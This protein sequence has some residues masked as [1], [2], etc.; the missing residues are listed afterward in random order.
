M[1]PNAPP[2]YTQTPVAKGKHVARP[3]GVEQDADALAK[4]QARVLQLE[5]MVQRMASAAPVLRITHNQDLKAEGSRFVG[6]HAASAV[7][8]SVVVTVRNGVEGT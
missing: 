5:E 3:V 4:L 8:H 1:E 7:Q 2:S 6:Y